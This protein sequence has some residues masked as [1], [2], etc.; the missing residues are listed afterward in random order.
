MPELPE[1]ETIACGLRALIPG[2]RIAEVHLSGKKLR[3]PIPGTFARKLQGR[4]ISRIHRIGKYLILELDP[5]AYLLVHLG[6]SGRIF[7]PA[8]RAENAPHTHMRIRFSDA[9]EMH[10]RDYRRFGLL[11]VYEVDDI[12]QIP[13]LKL[14]GADPLSS[15]VNTEALWQKLHPCRQPVKSFLLDQKK[16]A[17]VGNIYACEAMFYAGIHPSRRCCTLTRAETDRLIRGIRK[18]LHAGLKHGGTTF[19]DF[20]GTDGAPG[21]NQ[22]FLKV[23]QREERKCRRCGSFIKRLRQGN[24]STFYCPQCQPKRKQRKANP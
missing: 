16:I 24:R 14:M 10:Y 6:M 2:K 9:T 18:S 1:V 13:E 22:N 11:A 4:A 20:L 19:S 5:H 17:G 23:Y 3:K 21:S 8:G 12:R 15:E 7:Y